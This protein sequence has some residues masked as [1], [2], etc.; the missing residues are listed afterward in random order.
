[1]VI[2]IKKK[3]HR[4]DKQNILHYS[5]QKGQLKITVAC[6]M[7]TT[8]IIKH[9]RYSKRIDNRFFHYTLNL[10]CIISPSLTR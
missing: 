3:Y 10:K 9:H 5:L 1:M 4:P 7:Q 8:V 2:L 6:R